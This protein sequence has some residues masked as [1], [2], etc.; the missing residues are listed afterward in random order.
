MSRII[1][2]FF[3]RRQFFI[4]GN[5]FP[6]L[7]GL[8]SAFEVEIVLTIPKGFVEVSTAFEDSCVGRIA[9]RFAEAAD[10]APILRFWV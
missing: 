4:H 2:L 9:F 8:L 5:D 6:K 1:H 7:V 10:D 3:H